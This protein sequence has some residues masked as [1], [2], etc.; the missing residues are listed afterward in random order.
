MVYLFHLPNWTYFL[1]ILNK[2]FFEEKAC[3]VLALKVTQ[4]GKQSVFDL[5]T[6]I[7][8]KVWHSLIPWTLYFNIN[9]YWT[10]CLQIWTLL[11]IYQYW[12][13]FTVW[14]WTYWLIGRFYS[15]L[16]FKYPY[17]NLNFRLPRLPSKVCILSTNR[18]CTPACNFK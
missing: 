17:Y 6:Q 14:L 13:Q 11:L 2:V 8:C 7:L 4:S 5:K 3:Q 10:P 12:V 18:A 1:F 15:R 9:D 16:V